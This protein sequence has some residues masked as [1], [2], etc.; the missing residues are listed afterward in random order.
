M[1]KF[2]VF[3]LVVVFTVAVP[4]GAVPT[5]PPIPEPPPTPPPSPPPEEPEQG[6]GGTIPFA[7]QQQ[8][9]E[10]ISAEE[11]M[12]GYAGGSMIFNLKVIQK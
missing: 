4:V 6:G 11:I 7:E 5:V 2:M 3:A 9:F 10:V 12:E 8:K 1:K